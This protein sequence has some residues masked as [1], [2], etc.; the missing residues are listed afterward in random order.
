LLAY[1]RRIYYVL[2]DGDAEEA[3][4][5]VRSM[6]EIADKVP[7]PFLRWVALYQAGMMAQLHGRLDAADAL[8]EEAVTVGT[9]GDQPDA[10]LLYAG[11]QFWLRS[12][13]GRVDEVIDL[14]EQSVE[15]YPGLPVWRGGY[16]YL[17]CEIG[18]GDEALALLAEEDFEALPHDFL[19]L[20]GLAY[21]A[22]VCANVGAVEFADDLYARL[23]PFRDQVIGNGVSMVGSVN[24]FL[25]RLSAAAGDHDRAGREFEAAAA[26]H[27]RLDAP[28][29]LARTEEAWARA[30]LDR[31]RA[32]DREHASALLESAL[33]GAREHGADG[34]A[35]RVEA[36]VT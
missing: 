14:V 31:G 20:A 1:N 17:L 6:L 30:L 32:D 27:R 15:D 16:A 3:D 4:E 35:R 19:R 2:E 36:A 10:V 7:Q 29:I 24:H 22:D 28:V 11:Q 23:E 34:I 25:G 12:D 21:W 5:C 18:R 33:T 13:Q 8:I 26:A 9:D